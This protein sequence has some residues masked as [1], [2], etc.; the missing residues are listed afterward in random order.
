MNTSHFTIK[1]QARISTIGE[2]S[3]KT[4]RIWLVLHGYGQLSRYFI[5]KFESLNDGKSL[6]IAPEGL[7]RFYLSG[8]SG[9]VGASWMTKEDRLT[10]IADNHRYLDDL[11]KKFSEACP[12]ARK[13]IIGFS[14]GAATAVRWFC[15]AENRPE[16]IVIWSGAFP[17][18][19][20]WFNDI[21]TL[22]RHRPVFVLGDK[23]EF[24]NEERVTEQSTWLRDQGLEFDLVRFEGGHDIHKETLQT[25]HL[26]L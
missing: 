7:H 26:S 6:I 22:N 1:K 18:D 8:Y 21:P 10:D 25:L 23:D 14:Q 24:Y 13:G 16:R 20:D 9:R 17:E 11:W 4:E 2:A 12:K 15:Q 3:E 19:L 5:H